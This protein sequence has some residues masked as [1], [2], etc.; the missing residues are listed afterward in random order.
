M[1]YTNS[2]F[3]ASIALPKGNSINFSSI[4]GNV[5]SLVS[6]S[7]TSGNFNLVLPDTAGTINQTL[8]INN[9]ISNDIILIIVTID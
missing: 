3:N 1:S 2:Y 4:N 8:S 6:S 7:N 9:V 5:V